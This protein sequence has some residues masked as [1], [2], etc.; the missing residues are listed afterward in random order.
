MRLATTLTVALVLASLATVPATA[1]T[2]S[3]ECSAD[4]WGMQGYYNE[5]WN[6]DH[7]YGTQT[8]AYGSVMNCAWNS[9]E[10][11]TNK[12]FWV[13]FDLSSISGT[14]T[15]A[16]LQMTRTGWPTDAYDAVLVGALNDGDPGENWGEYTITYNNAPG[17][18]PNDYPLN[19][20]GGG[21]VTYMGAIDYT[22]T[23]EVGDV[24]TMSSDALL[25]VVNGDTNGILT[26]GFTKRGYDVNSGAVFASRENAF[27]AGATLVLTSSEPV[28]VYWTGIGDTTWS[29]ATGLNNWKNSGGTAADYADGAPVTFDDTATGVS[30]DI[31]AA[32]VLP[33]SVTF[34]NSALDFTITGAKGIAGATGVM[35]QGTRKVTF[36]CVNAYTGVTTVQAGTLQMSESSYGNVATNAG[37]ADIQGGKGVLDYSVSGVSPAPEVQALLTASYH[38]GAWDVGQIRNTTAATT[39]LTLGWNDD[40]TASQV[41]IMATYTGDADLSGTVNV[42]DLTALLNNYNKAGMVWGGGDFNY[43]SVVNVADLTALLN[44]YNRSIGESVAAGGGLSAGSSAVPE[45]G[46]IAL[47]ATGLLG[48][49]AGLRLSRKGR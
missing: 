3:L 17:N 29:P 31:S 10:T 42:A 28:P 39:G 49:L 36:N 8:D 47:L 22:T 46:T 6:A 26:L 11:V 40:T 35:K 15:G 20:G 41:T 19:W 16:T 12:K 7:N 30:V 13:K 44:N 9:S 1:A 38:G 21:N 18:V 25:A 32:D 5:D 48:L 23:G 24:L 37:G 45:P 34:N 43:D 33:A 14:V 27:Y 2:I 4:A